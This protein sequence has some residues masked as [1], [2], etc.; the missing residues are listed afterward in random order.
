M[1][2][3]YHGCAAMQTRDQ[4]PFLHPW[5]CH[6]IRGKKPELRTEVNSAGHATIDFDCRRFVFRSRNS[7][8]CGLWIRQQISVGAG[9]MFGSRQISSRGA[10]T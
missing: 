1:A 9:V 10:N 5:Y 7:A 4:N 6:A 8:Y 2:W 3:Q